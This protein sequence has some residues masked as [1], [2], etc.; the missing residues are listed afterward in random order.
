MAFKIFKSYLFISF[1]ILL[2][3]I[4]LWENG[5]PNLYLS[6]FHFGAQFICLSFFYKRIFVNRFQK[7]LVDII[8]FI[9]ISLLFIKYYIEP[10]LFFKFNIF[11]IFICSFPLA[12]YSII[13]LYNSLTRKGVYMYIN[14]GVL[15]YLSVSTLIFILGNFIASIDRGLARNIWF[16]NKIFYIMYLLLIYI[17]WN[18]N[19]RINNN[20]RR[21]IN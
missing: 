11:E 14:A 10:E 17:E 9:V 1:L 16:L 21:I 6:H 13:H 8:L 3:S 18:K 4:Y 19:I 15:I 20:G 12:L 2:Y 7:R 5:I